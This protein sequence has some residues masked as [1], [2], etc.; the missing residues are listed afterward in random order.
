MR[1]FLL[2][3]K[4]A[5]SLIC[6]SASL[7][8]DSQEFKVN[9]KDPTFSKGSI[10]TTQGGVIEAEDLRIQAKKIEYTNKTENGLPVKKVVAEGD[11]LLEYRN[12]AFVGRRLEYDFISKT[13]TVW[14]GR[15]STEYWFLGGDEIELLSDGSFR[16]LNA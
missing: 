14:N 9:L 4:F 10:T 3:R 11:L 13:G 15:T 1:P 6:D 7:C 2:C 5:F 8:A 12:Q 16:I